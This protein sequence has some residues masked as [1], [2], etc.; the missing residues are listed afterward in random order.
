MSAV[1]FDILKLAVLKYIET[2]PEKSNPGSISIHKW[3]YLIIRTNGTLCINNLSHHSTPL[4][5]KKGKKCLDTENFSIFSLLCST[6]LSGFLFQIL[7]CKM[8]SYFSWGFSNIF[9]ANLPT[10]SKL[11]PAISPAGMN[12]LEL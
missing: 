6:S 2:C 8:N 4:Y 1:Y 7:R 11:T 3:L 10:I 5:I 9:S 12:F